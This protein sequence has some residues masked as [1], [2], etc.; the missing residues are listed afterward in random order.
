[1]ADAAQNRVV[2]PRA[3]PSPAAVLAANLLSAS[4]GGTAAD[5]S[6]LRAAEQ[7][8]SAPVVIGHNAGFLRRDAAL[9]LVFVSDEPDQSPDAVD[10]YVDFYQS[11]KGTRHAHRVS[12]SAVA[13]PTPPG[14]C[15][16]PGGSARADG[17]YEA[18]ARQ[19]GGVFAS[20]CNPS[21]ATVMSDLAARV[22]GTPRRFILRN[23]PVMTTLQ[24]FVDGTAVPSI[25]P[26][27][28]VNWTYDLPSNSV[29]FTPLGAASSPTATVRI[30]Y[31]P[32]CQ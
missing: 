9:A 13:A 15:T 30:E 18:A 5:E 11:I 22:F 2:T 4:S 17:R 25:S 14:N 10:R 32:D 8:L 31:A 12:V 19:T 7:A 28:G 21:W 3:G 1:M 6:G 29:S 16:G 24:V 20:I 27:G 23:H 26:A